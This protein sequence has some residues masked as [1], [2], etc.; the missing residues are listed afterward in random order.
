MKSILKLSKLKNGAVLHSKTL[1]PTGWLPV[2]FIAAFTPILQ[3]RHGALQ[4]YSG[5]KN[6]PFGKMYKY[7]KW[8]NTSS[9]RC[10]ITIFLKRR[11]SKTFLF[12]RLIATTIALFS[13][14]SP[15]FSV[16]FNT[17]A[18]YFIGFLPSLF[19]AGRNK[20]NG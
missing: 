4:Y 11:A 14:E 6:V 12:L 5:S 18:T 10:M 16:N 2:G 13:L 8:Q 15:I 20:V 3:K 19:F 9:P 7:F 1:Q 17:L